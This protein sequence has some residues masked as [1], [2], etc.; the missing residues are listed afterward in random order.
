MESKYYSQAGQDKWVLEKVGNKGFFVDVGA[1][2]GIESSNTY[3]LEL[4]G[5]D[6]ICFEPNPEAFAKLKKNRKCITSDLFISNQDGVTSKLS[7]AL[8]A[9]TC[10]IDYLSIDVDGGEMKVLQ[11]M[12]FQRHK[13]RLITIEHN[14][15]LEGPARQEEIFQYLTAQG[16]DRVVKDVKC[17][18]P[19]YFGMIYEDW[20]ENAEYG[21]WINGEFNYAHST[22][23]P[24]RK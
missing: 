17:L 7:S 13:V 19:N 3:A 12:D 10:V 6:G 5:W 14:Q 21:M 16:F 23:H 15:Y 20:Y 18:D 2:D 1:Y 9:C 11:G 4:A 24:K 22:T 8:M